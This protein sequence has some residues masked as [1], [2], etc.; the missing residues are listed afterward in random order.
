MFKPIFSD[1][2]DANFNSPIDMYMDYKKKK[3]EGVLNYQDSIIR[4]Y[5]EHENFTHSDIALELPTG[6][7]KTLVGLLIAEYRRRKNK[8]KVLYVCPTKQLVNQ[9][10]YEA[11][12]IYD[13]PT[14][15]FT[16]SSST[17][18][19]EDISS[20]N[21]TSKIGVTNYSSV[22]NSNPYFKDV[23]IIIFDDAHSAE[24][25]VSSNWTVSIKKNDHGN[26][27]SQLA[28]LLKDHISDSSYYLLTATEDNSLLNFDVDL[29]PR[30]II[31]RLE[32]DIV[33]LV[34][35]FINS[36]SNFRFSWGNIKL[37]L[38]GCSMYLSNNLI[39]I[40]PIISPT[41]ENEIFRDA[42]QR[43]YMS[44]TLGKSNS[45]HQTFAKKNIKQINSSD[46]VPSIGRRLF[47][48]PETKFQNDD[49]FEVIKGIKALQSNMLVLT[50]SNMELSKI[51]DKLREILPDETSYFYSRD[52][53]QSLDEFTSS[54][55]G[56][57]ILANRFDGINLKEDDCRI[58]LMNNL[59]DNLNMQEK[60][61]S[62]RLQAA[63]IND[64][65]IR[66]KVTQA[67]GRC[68]RS[69]NDFS[70]VIILGNDLQSELSNQ[71]K[72]KLYEPELRAEIEV[73]Y[74][75]SK[76][77]QTPEDL[78]SVVEQAFIQNETW[79]SIDSQIIKIRDVYKVEKEGN[80]TNQTSVDIT[81]DLINFQYDIWDK[82]YEDAIKSAE[83][84]HSNIKESNLNGFRAYWDYEKGSIYDILYF[85]SGSQLDKNQAIKAYNSASDK[86]RSITWFNELARELNKEEPIINK[87]SPKNELMIS[88]QI[89]NI[90]SICQKLKGP[91]KTRSFNN[92]YSELPDQLTGHSSTK[93]LAE[94]AFKQLGELLGFH[95][96]NP[97]LTADPDPYWLISNDL[98]LVSEMK[99]YR[100]IEKPISN[101]DYRQSLEHSTWIK[102]NVENLREDADIFTIFI[103]NSS[104]LENSISGSE[105]TIYFMDAHKLREFSIKVISVLRTIISSFSEIDDFNWLNNTE[106]LLT[107]N[108]LD[109]QSIVDLFLEKQ[110]LELKKN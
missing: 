59:P 37:N 91:N 64:E 74:E 4:K 51:N 83:R 89:K 11:N 38:S 24:N 75:I 10:T 90:E 53:E 100:S 82:R 104:I 36:D 16:G 105:E 88:H 31:H 80:E 69:H 57:A 79:D 86:T 15:S 34:D 8:E 18:S 55:N 65:T 56:V 42:T 108:K 5:M 50:E 73:G 110:I 63:S 71:R 19:P 22:F 32:K 94:K 85:N 35:S 58:L 76:Q 27:F 26:L 49:V 9:I 68:T 17:Y 46:N 87:E 3:I 20:F 78:V 84:V 93:S 99:M 61:F 1:N 23:D 98:C 77:V 102:N 12:N 33:D 54:N 96:V 66:T 2:D 47:I 43:I 103:S 72:L 14:V 106:T 97:N 60:F 70:V 25:Y 92:K 6:S 45:L 13:I 101:K 39:E 67:V 107:E 109:A 21:D 28:E 29:V 44:A 81:T 40:K 7:G 41:R 52:L 95:S 48:F 30:S 62:S